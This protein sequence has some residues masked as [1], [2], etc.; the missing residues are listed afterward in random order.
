ML[1]PSQGHCGF[2][3]FPVVDWFCLFADL[4][5]LPFPLE[6]CLVFSNFVITLIYHNTTFINRYSNT[7]R[8]LNIFVGT[9]FFIWS[10]IVLKWYNSLQYE[11]W[12]NKNS[13]LTKCFSTDHKRIFLIIYVT[14]IPNYF[15]IKTLLKYL[16]FYGENYQ[17][18][19]NCIN[20]GQLVLLNHH[21]LDT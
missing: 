3:S 4:R 9:F 10:V 14:E 1:V 15:L 19:N 8:L 5:V 13:E 17:I 7:Q 2:P 11:T 6:D 16:V 21:V 18:I 12:D 20:T